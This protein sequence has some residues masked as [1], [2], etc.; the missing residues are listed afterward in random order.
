M[1]SHQKINYESIIGRDPKPAHFSPDEIVRFQDERFLV[2]GAGGSI[3][4]R[5]VK[6]LSTIP[7]IEY[8]ATDRDESSLHSLSLSL[9]HSALFDSDRFRLL[10]VRDYVGIQ[11]CFAEYKPTAVIHAAALKHLSVLQKQPRE[12]IL[13]N[14]FGS[15]NLLEVSRDFGV[16]SF[17]N[18]ST[19][20]AA[21]PTSVLGLSKHLVELYTAE[22]RKKGYPGFTSCRFGN[23]FNS[24]G[25]VIETFTRQMSLG[26]PIT[27]TDPSVERFFMHVDEAAF[28]TL[29]SFLSNKGDVH[30]F[31]MGEPVLMLDIVRKMQEILLSSSQILITGLR[32]GE[33]IQEQLVESDA[34]EIISEYDEIRVISFEN[35]HLDKYFEPLSAVTVRDYDAIYELLTQSS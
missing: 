28:L 33:K 6:L 15:A 22:F 31:E 24:R 29:K 18:I 2:T 13:T 3:G 30:I 16:T 5:I 20:K 12:A 14:V 25:S 35:T 8:L 19:D 27:L 26:V 11:E 23:V 9:T 32:D 34:H 17:V 21:A 10:D 4:S 7:N 1:D